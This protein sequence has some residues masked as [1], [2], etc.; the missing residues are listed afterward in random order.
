[1]GDFSREGGGFTLDLGLFLMIFEPPEVLL[2]FCDDVAGPG[3]F[4]TVLATGVL[5]TL[6][7]DFAET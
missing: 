3:W 5:P 7:G 6:A 2:C 1:M 4:L